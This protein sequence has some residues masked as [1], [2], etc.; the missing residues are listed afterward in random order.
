MLNKAGSIASATDGGAS[1]KMT[2]FLMWALWFVFGAYSVWF[3]TKAKRPQ[4]LTLDELV[5]LWK[6]HKQQSG[7]DTPLSKMDPIT[8]SHTNEFSGFRCRCGYKYQSQ[9]LI[10]QRHALDKSMFL[11]I[12]SNTPE[13]VHL[14][15]T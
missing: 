12:S 3:V 8:N 1:V 11:G 4:A 5:L 10:V 14:A 6:I 15:E 7:C 9:R 13:S 2:D